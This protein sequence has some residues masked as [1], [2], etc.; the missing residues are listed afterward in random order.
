[1]SSRVPKLEQD[2]LHGLAGEYAQAVA[3]YTEACPAAVL[4][5]T[6]VAFG[7]AVN[8]NAFM[9]VGGTT[10]YVNEFALLVGPT[11]TSRKGDSMQLGI[12]PI[13]QANPEWRDCLLGGFGSGE[14]VVDAVRDRVTT[15]GR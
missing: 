6:L 10:H 8:R 7:N 12:R 9:P 11:A 1:V 5:A 14:A 3:P 13:E 2:A 4:V 15:L